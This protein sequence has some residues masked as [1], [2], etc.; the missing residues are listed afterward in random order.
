MALSKKGLRKLEYKEITF[1]WRIRAKPTYSQGA[2]RSPMTLA[3]Q[4]MD[5]ESPKILHV[6][7]DIDRPDN[8]IASHQTQITPEVIRQII[9]TALKTGWQLRIIQIDSYPS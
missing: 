5:T 7:L 4:S 8:W 9:D 3:I 2:F 1:G 6:T